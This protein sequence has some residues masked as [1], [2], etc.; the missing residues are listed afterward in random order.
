MLEEELRHLEFKCRNICGRKDAA[1]AGALHEGLAAGGGEP[2][3]PGGWRAQEYELS[4]ISELPEKSGQGQHQRYNTGESCRST[5]LLAELP[6]LES[7]CGGQPQGGNSNLNRTPRE[8]LASPS[9]RLLPP[10]PRGA[11]LKFRS[12]SRDPRRGPE[13][14][15]G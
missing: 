13:T 8:P 4:D 7:P 2:V 9:P 12:L 15:L 11:P 3:R 1:A 14:A 6:C 5:P 10:P